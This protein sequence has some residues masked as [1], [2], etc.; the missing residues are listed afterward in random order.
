MTTDIFPIYDVTGA[1]SDRPEAL[2]TKEKFWLLP[3]AEMGLPVIPH[4]FKIGRPNTGENWSEK[5]S[6]EILAHLEIPAARYNFA[7]CDGIAG[8][9]SQR[10]MPNPASFWPA[11]TLLARSVPEYDGTRRFKQRKYQLSTSVGILRTLPI[12]SPLS[13]GPTYTNLSAAELFVGYLVFDSLI[14]NTD[15]HHE[16]WGVVVVT[17]EDGHST[18][19]LAPTFDHAS[20]LGRN[21]TDEARLRRLETNDTRDNV[22]AYA[23]RARS[24]FYR[25]ALDERT[26]SQR[27]TLE[28]LMGAYPAITRFWAGVMAG[29]PPKVFEGIFSRISEQ[30]ISASAVA[31]ALEMLRANQQMIREVAGG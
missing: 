6:Y 7:I 24:A 16:N 17:D 29:I 25:S 28:E 15:R 22:A 21:E 31:F 4:L 20:C 27:E 8:V 23:G 10:F 3:S 2:G 19:H 5:A 12:A 9:I 11:N 13:T 30:L 18:F 26:M 1:T 14:G